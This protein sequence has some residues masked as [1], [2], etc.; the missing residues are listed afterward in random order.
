MNILWIWAAAFLTLCVFSFLYKDNPFYRFAEHLVVGVSLGYSVVML[1][2]TSFIPYVWEP[3]AI[4]HEWFMILPT[5]LGL[6]FLTH[7]IP[8]IAWL[9]RYPIS[10]LMGIGNGIA[11]PISLQMNILKQISATMVLLP[12]LGFSWEL[13]NNLLI[14]IGVLCTLI[15]FYFSKPHVGWWGRLANV[16]IVY[17]MVG[18]GATFGY[19]VMAR[20]SLLIGRIEFLLNTWL[21]VAK[22]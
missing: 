9:V 22:F 13:V 21:H 17:L 14:M 6:L 8:K 19:T 15:Y 2:K 11:I 16:G 18:F 7:L 10:F 1:Y 12:I 5:L 20:L 4:R 3:L